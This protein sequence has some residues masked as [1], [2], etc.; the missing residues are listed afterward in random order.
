MI[1]NHWIDEE[2]LARLL[3][4]AE[5]AHA[6]YQ[7]QLGRSD[8]SWPAWYAHYVVERLPTAPAAEVPAEPYIAG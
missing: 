5:A 1:I 4:E 3:A 7:R 8:P 6:Q 2:T